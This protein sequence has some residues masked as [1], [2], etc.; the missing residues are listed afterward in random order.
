[1]RTGGRTPAVDGTGSV[2]VSGAVDGGRT[3]VAVDGDGIVGNDDDDA[4]SVGVGCTVDCSSTDGS[5]NGAG[6]VGV[7]SAFNGPG[8]VVVSDAVDGSGTVVADD[9]AVDSSEIVVA[10]D[11]DA[12]SVGVSGTVDCSSTDDSGTPGNG[13]SLT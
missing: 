2:V 6:S 5:V 10:V 9:C 12:G 4:G 13:S 8:L 3:V 11:D 7:S 1:M